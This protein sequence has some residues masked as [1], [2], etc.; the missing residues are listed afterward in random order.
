MESYQIH[1]K[2]RFLTWRINVEYDD[3]TIRFF[4]RSFPYLGAMKEI[5]SFPLEKVIFCG[6][7]NDVKKCNR[8]YI[9]YDG[10]YN[11]IPTKTERAMDDRDDWTI[12][13]YTNNGQSDLDAD[14]SMYTSTICLHLKSGHLAQ[15]FHHL[16]GL[17]FKKSKIKSE[18]L[19]QLY[20]HLEQSKAVKANVKKACGLINPQDIA[21][22]DKWLFHFKNRLIENGLFGEFETDSTPIK[23]MAFFVQQQHV[24]YCGYHR[25]VRVKI[26]SSETRK[27]LKDHCL[28]LAPR[29]SEEGSNFQSAKIASLKDLLNISRWIHP[30]RLSL[31]PNAVIFTRKTFRKDEMC[32]LPYERISTFL[33]SKGWFTRKVEFYGE[34]NIVPK[35]SFKN[36][37][38][39][40][41]ESILN[42]KMITVEHGSS[43]NSSKLFPQNWFGRGPRL[44]CL[45]D[46]VNYY[47]GRLKNKTIKAQV[48]SLKYDEIGK[49]TWYRPL[50]NPFGTLVFSGST[51]NIR[52]DQ[53]SKGSLCELPHLWTFRFKFILKGELYTIFKTKTNLKISTKRK[54]YE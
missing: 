39:A 46:K 13:Q 20:N 19:D 17:L 11:S 29:L 40:V 6:N 33:I 41:I 9:S 16:L 34:Q 22:T 8:V 15:L 5:A 50:F 23:E 10:T 44:L 51:K 26:N 18:P 1:T 45:H 49:I 37:D 30:D 28:K 52:V 48:V 54:S 32:Y 53:L 2:W 14:L 4:K 21:Y 7:D 25:Q 42:E 36:K 12:E 38:V 31:T 3:T 43:F 47:P 35:Y 24:V 27:K